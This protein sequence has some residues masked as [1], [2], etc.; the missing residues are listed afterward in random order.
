MPLD[1]KRVSAEVGVVD[2]DELKEI[3]QLTQQL[4]VNGDA[5]NVNYSDGEND[6]DKNYKWDTKFAVVHSWHR[7]NT[8]R[9][10]QLSCVDDKKSQQ[11][12]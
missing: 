5:K 1:V 11:S 10:L 7:Q 9:L 4:H 3:Q 12:T 8:K 6:G 2:M